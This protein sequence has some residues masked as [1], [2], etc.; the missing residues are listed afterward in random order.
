[1][2]KPRRSIFGPVPGRT[3]PEQANLIRRAQRDV[4]ER[5]SKTRRKVK[6]DERLVYTSARYYP[7]DLQTVEEL[8]AATGRTK[9]Y[10]L[11]VALHMFAEAV[12]ANP[13]EFI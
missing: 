10:I 9:G 7:E 11:R 4:A 2:T 13:R 8:A 12:R 6:P 3:D 1:M 5:E